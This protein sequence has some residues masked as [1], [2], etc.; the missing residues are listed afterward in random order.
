M[1]RGTKRTLAALAALSVTAVGAGA[2][3]QWIATRHDLAANPPPGR[4]V[5]VGGHRLHILCTGAGSPAVVLESGLG[6]S[7]ADWGFVQPGVAAFT[8]VCSYDRAGMGYSDPGPSPRTAR[9]IALELGQLVDRAGVDGPLVLVGA[10]LGGFT[11]RLFAS[12]R[13]ER[14]AG[15][16]LVDASHEDQEL[17]VPRIAPFMPFLSSVGVPRILGMPLGLPPDSVAPSARG[18]ARATRFRTAAYRAAV[19]EIVHVR[20]SAEQVR[21]GRRTLAIPLVVVTG[22]RGADAAWR[23]LQRDQVTLSRQGCQI[24]AEESGHVVGVGQPQ[25]VVDAV[26]ATVDVARGSKAAPCG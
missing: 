5:D 23:D 10:S 17:V 26:R 4:L 2:A 22:G 24:V 12:E 11:V 14:V 19:D 20:E 13:P 15:L 6:G 3:Y 7:S 18:A 9:R 8:R 25:A 21:A 16:V 1:W